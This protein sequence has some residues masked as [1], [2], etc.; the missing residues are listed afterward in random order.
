M[1]K[2]LLTGADGFFASRFYEFYKSKYEIIPLRRADLDIRD[3][4]RAL[5]LLNFHKPDLVIHTAAVADTKKCEDNPEL[6][7]D[8]N[9]LGTK[10]IAKACSSIKAKLIHLSTEQLYNGNIERGPYS[11]DKNLPKPDTVYGKHKLT[12]EKELLSIIEEAWVMRLTWMFG[13]PER[14]CKVNSNIV[15]NIISAALKGKSLRLPGNEF[16]GMT[17]VYDVLRNIEAVL[18]VPYGIYNT[19]SEN[20]MS[21][22]EAGCL[23]LDKMGLGYK[24]D[25]I[26]IK[27]EDRYKDKPRDLR[28][29]NSKFKSVGIEFMETSEAIEK[30][31]KD[32]NYNIG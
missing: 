4:N 9:V 7:Y 29:D 28:I 15:W 12:A 8:I 13:L 11:E 3:E 24:I 23:V 30:C 1:K 16:R 19:G 17:Y 32:F 21:T 25:E 6:S 22:Y 2:V 5:E 20:D 10:N 27:D 26:I 18:D 31:I 14:G